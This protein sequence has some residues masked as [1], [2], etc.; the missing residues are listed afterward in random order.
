MTISFRTRL[1]AV[2]ALIVGAVRHLEAARGQPAAS[3]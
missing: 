2:A 1:F 3:L